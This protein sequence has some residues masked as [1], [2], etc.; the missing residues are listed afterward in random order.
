MYVPHMDIHVQTT[1]T[2]LHTCTHSHGHPPCTL[3]HAPRSSRVCVPAP[4]GAGE[5]EELR[6]GPMTRNT[7]LAVEAIRLKT[8][9]TVFT[10]VHM[11]IVIARAIGTYVH[12]I[13][14]SSTPF[15]CSMAYV[16]TYTHVVGIVGCL[17]TKAGPHPAGVVVDPSPPLPFFLYQNTPLLTIGLMSRR[18]RLL[19][20]M[21]QLKDRIRS[22]EHPVRMTTSSNIRLRSCATP[23][24]SC[25]T[26]TRSCAIPATN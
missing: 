12:T 15:Y 2:T 18:S 8:I 14:T 7:E 26:P 11:S 16:H 21:H 13:C 1:Q 20:P 19:W 6:K 10:Y 23:N 24:T 3:P 5:G 9:H 25:A 22:K 4:G 17:L